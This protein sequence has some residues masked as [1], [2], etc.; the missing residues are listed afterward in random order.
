MRPVF[1]LSL[2]IA[3]LAAA[4]LASRAQFVDRGQQVFN[5]INMQ[6]VAMGLPPLAD[7][8]T[9]DPQAAAGA[10]KQNLDMLSA[11]CFQQSIGMS[12]KLHEKMSQVCANGG[13]RPA[14]AG[15]S[16]C[17]RSCNRLN[18]TRTMSCMGSHY[19]GHC[20]TLRQSD[21]HQQCLENCRR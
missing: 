14:G 21:D 3:V 17:V 15:N 19:T 4:P 6:R 1:R 2:A 8:P 7:A 18:A 11:E 10:C 16:D 9:S 12:C 13:Q 5:Q 20:D